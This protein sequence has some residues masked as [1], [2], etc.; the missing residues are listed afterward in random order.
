MKARFHASA[1]RVSVNCVASANVG[2]PPERSYEM[3]AFRGNRSS[4]PGVTYYLTS[5]VLKLSMTS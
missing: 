5:I 2:N 3:G 1:G 4:S